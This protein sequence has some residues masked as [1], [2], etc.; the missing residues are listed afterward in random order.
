LGA[1]LEQADPIGCA[2]RAR[3]GPASRRRGEGGPR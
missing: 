3:S 2:R 1:P